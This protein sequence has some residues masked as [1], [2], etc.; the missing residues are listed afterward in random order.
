[1]K[2]LKVKDYRIIT[3]IDYEEPFD[4]VEFSGLINE[5]IK[6]GYQLFGEPIVKPDV[7]CIVYSQAMV[8]LDD[9]KEVVNEEDDEPMSARDLYEIK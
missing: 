3:L 2:P 5:Y 1:M 9:E 4:G 7:P 8:L 6:K